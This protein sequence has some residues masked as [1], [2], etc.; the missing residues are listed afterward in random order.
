MTPRRRRFVLIALVLVGVVT[1]TALALRA[2]N[3]NLLFFFSPSEVVAGDAPLER[4]FRMGGLVREGSIEREAGSMTVR[5]VVTDEAHDVPVT[6]TGVLPDLFL[7]NQGV[8][9]RGRLDGGGGFVAD[10]VLA[11]HDENYMPV[12]VAD[13]LEQA[14]RTL[15][16]P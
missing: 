6:Y 14:R 2:F 12:E 15:Q 3:E 9:V 5:F 1:A 4:A 8:V 13:A 16:Q 7:E 10:E 11:R